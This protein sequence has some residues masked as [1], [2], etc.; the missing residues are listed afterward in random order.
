MVMKEGKANP[1]INHFEAWLISFFAYFY[2]IFFS[3]L[4]IV[5]SNGLGKE[6]N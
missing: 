1:F 2:F 5:S 4:I 6:T 3:E